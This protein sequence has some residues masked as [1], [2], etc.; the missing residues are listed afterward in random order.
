MDGIVGASSG[1]MLFGYYG[2]HAVVLL[3]ADR[4]HGKYSEILILQA[5]SR[6]WWPQMARNK[7]DEVKGGC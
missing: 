5:P 3:K 2:R 7:E 1:E 4:I 6:S